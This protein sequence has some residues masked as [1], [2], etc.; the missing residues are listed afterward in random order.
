MRILASSQY[1]F[2]PIFPNVQQTARGLSAQA[3]GVMTYCP[4]LTG[5]G[6]VQIGGYLSG[7]T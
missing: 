7:S 1:V 5:A 4:L 6:P 2:L 3:P